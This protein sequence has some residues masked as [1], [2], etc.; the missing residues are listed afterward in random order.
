[1]KK[2]V[3]DTSAL[4]TF[5]ENEEGVEEVE[6]L[7]KQALDGRIELF[8]SIISSIEIFYISFREQGERIANERLELIEDLPIVQEALTNKL[9]KIIGKIKTNK[10][11]SFADSCIAG[12][13]KLKEAFL[14]HKDTEYECIENEVKQHK[15]PYKKRIKWF[16]S[17]FGI[18]YWKISRKIHW[19][20]EYQLLKVI[21]VNLTN[22][23]IKK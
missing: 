12:L 6:T 22:N 15:L 19:N 23:N 7:F 9:I 21:S 16:I 18:L 8:I 13:S 20:R 3:L 2:Y 5:I 10:N 4:L 14:V 17:D 1:M 11:I